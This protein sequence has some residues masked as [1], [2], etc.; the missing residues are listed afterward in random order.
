MPQRKTLKMHINLQLPEGE[1]GDMIKN[2]L[3]HG[4]LSAFA[5]TYIVSRR[6]EG[7]TWLDD[8]MN[9][10]RARVRPH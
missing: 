9:G 6:L 10:V 7:Q 5:S 3:T 4:A 2:S 8:D 1:A